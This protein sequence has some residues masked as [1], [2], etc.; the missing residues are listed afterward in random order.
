MLSALVSP[1]HLSTCTCTSL[2]QTCGLLTVSSLSAF[3]PIVVFSTSHLS[4]LCPVRSRCFPDILPTCIRCPD[5]QACDDGGGWREGGGKAEGQVVPVPDGPGGKA[6]ISVVCSTADSFEMNF[7]LCSFRAPTGSCCRSSHA[8]SAVLLLFAVPLKGAV[9]GRGGNNLT[10]R[11]ISRLISEL[12]QMETL[13]GEVV[14]KPENQRCR[15][16]G[17]QPQSRLSPVFASTQTQRRLV[18]ALDLGLS[19]N[20][21][22]GLGV[23]GFRLVSV[24]SCDCMFFD[25][26]FQTH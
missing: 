21:D 7:L 16:R 4:P 23:K 22:W 10:A 18:G 14:T 26:L 12:I 11:E 24:E 13:R 25:D 2:L 20:K 19:P 9:A 5:T 6:V 3:S 15:G 8:T 1:R 17:I